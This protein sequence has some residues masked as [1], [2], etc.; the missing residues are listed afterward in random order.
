MR[1]I[2][3]LIDG[4]RHLRVLGLVF[5][6]TL[7]SLPAAHGYWDV[8]NPNLTVSHVGTS[9]IDVPVEVVSWLSSLLPSLKQVDMSSLDGKA[10]GLAVIAGEH[11][12]S[13]P[14]DNFDLMGAFVEGSLVAQA[15]IAVL[16]VLVIL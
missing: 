16:E 11:G 14:G 6:A 7:A 10:G 5:H 12:I 4:L 2:V 8:W 1:G 3:S 13:F 9:P 15:P